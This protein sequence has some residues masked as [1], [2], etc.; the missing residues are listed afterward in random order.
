MTTAP[1]AGAA[2]RIPGW[3]RAL[4][5]AVLVLA[6]LVVIG[7]FVQVFLIASYLFS[8]VTDQDLLDTHKDMGFTVHSVEVLTFVVAI[9]AFWRRWV[10][11]GWAFALG[12]LGTVQIGLADSD[13]KYVGGLHGMF[14]LLV[15]ILAA[16]VVHRTIRSLGMGR[17]G[18]MPGA[19]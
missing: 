15:L 7:V 19:Y 4:R 9:G 18:R 5:W 10:D 2:R 8:G 17:T 12:V 16:V 6:T 3:L 13:D 1:E 11:L 14:A